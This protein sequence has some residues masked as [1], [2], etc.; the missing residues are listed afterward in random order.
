MVHEMWIIYHT[1]VTYNQLGLL[2]TYLDKV[3]CLFIRVISFDGLQ[4]RGSKEVSFLSV[5][6]WG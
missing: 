2:M 6:Q 4:I 1:R 5:T 3:M